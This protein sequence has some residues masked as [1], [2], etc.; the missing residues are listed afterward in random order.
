MKAGV[1]FRGAVALFIA[2]FLYQ[3]S[4][5]AD[6]FALALKPDGPRIE[7]WWPT[8]ITSAGQQVW[9]EYEVQYSADLTNWIP[10]GGKVRGLSGL[11]GPLLNL[12]LE[13]Q[14]GPV[15]YRIIGDPNSPATNETGSGGAEVLGYD[16]EFSTRLN[17]IG[18]LSLQDFATNA[19]KVAYQPQ[20]TWDPTTAQF[21]TNFSSTNIHMD[22]VPLAYPWGMGTNIPYNY[23]LDTN[24]MA[25]F[26]T[27]GF[28]VS[29]RLGSASFGDAYYRIFNADLPVFVTSDSVLHAW[30]KSYQSILEELE[31]YELSPLLEQVT[32]N[33]S[34]QLPTIWQQY[35][36]GP[37]GNSILD[38]DYFLTVARSLW[39]TQQV[40]SAL[41]NADVNQQVANTLA[42][43]KSQ[44]PV[45]G[46][47]IFGSF[48][49]ID[50]SQF[51]VRGHYT[52]SDQ[53][54]RYFRALMWCSRIDL[55]LAT[56]PPNKEDDIRQLGTAIVMYYLLNQ[57]G[58]FS[59]WSTLEQV[60]RMFVGVTDSMTFAQLGELLANAKIGSPGDIPDLP[61]L[62]NLQTRLLSGELGAQNIQGDDLLSPFSREQLKLPRSFTVCGQKFVLDSWVFSQTV[63]DR[64]LWT[65][66]NGTNIMLGKVTRRKPSCL[67]AAFAVLGNDQIVP[68]LVAR[69]TNENGV[70]FRDGPN[71]PYQHNLLAV[72][73]TIDQQDPGNW[74]D[75]IYSAWLAA[76]RA[77]SGPTTDSI[78]P[79][80]MRTRSWAMK[81]LNTQLASWTQLRHDTLLYVKPSYTASIVCGYPAGFVEPRPGFWRQMK[82]LATIA[83]NSISKLPAGSALLLNV[84]SNQMSFL[85]NFSAQIST[86]ESISEKE[87]AQQPLSL[88]ETDFLKNVVELVSAYS[89]YRQW[90]GWYPQLFYKN[91]QFLSIWA[92]PPCDLWDALVT[93]VHTDP[94]DPF[95]SGDPGA[96]I[97][98]GIANV[99]LMLIAV[100]NGPDRMVY[101]GPVL[102]HYEFELAGVNRM[103]DQ[104]W[105]SNVLAGQKPAQPGWTTSYLVPG[106][107]TIPPGNQ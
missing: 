4:R 12:S 66:D 59:N 90:N 67:D 63:F 47:P 3:L 46:F 22:S 7:L 96:V 101:A 37:L 56:F 18:L 76:L 95:F 62:T 49:E 48:R 78:Y 13:Q 35:G 84:Q 40:A 9:P 20:L 15:F 79:E 52:D 24:E 53:L 70:P 43:I 36:Q 92:L 107:I 65:P 71:L 98:E 64:V 50:F 91:Y 58:Q 39:A 27:N 19:S 26:I 103:T 57:S 5:A 89:N 28:V 97:H 34:V 105:K 77:L 33:M 82:T 1:Y 44:V 29:E 21:W 73:Q 88:E 99:N 60:T 106:R 10:I 55:R 14:S 80:S 72:R 93:D 102:S 6:P 16:A 41:G 61:T 45:Q 69:M 25:I 2:L 75:N 32:S 100:D 68:E 11:S 31:Q 54:Q 42:S 104:Q 74:T 87:L 17:Q 83:A 38:A 81:T 94:P 30:H 51:I 23:L 8:A 86:L 85:S